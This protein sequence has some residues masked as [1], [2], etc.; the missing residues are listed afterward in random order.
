[1]RLIGDVHGKIAQYVALTSGCTS[2]IQ[3]GDFGA[4]FVELPQ[5]NTSHRFIRGNHDW[6]DACKLSP[7]WIADGTVEGDTFYMGGA[8]S[9]DQEM[10]TLGVDYW[11]DEELSW[12]ELECMINIYKAVKP[13]V[14][15][16]HEAPWIIGRTFWPHLT[17]CGSRTASALEAMWDLHK[18]ELHIFGHHHTNID[19]M[20]DTTRFICLAELEYIDI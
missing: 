6:L 11:P 8:Y 17:G 16:T 18:P 10:R 5:L 3:I 7:N 4:G 14:V 2:S 19:R 20:V 15:I 1:M 13:R 12:P 9:I